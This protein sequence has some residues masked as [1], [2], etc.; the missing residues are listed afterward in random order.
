M[1]LSIFR[2]ILWLTLIG[3][4]L[5]A[6]G[7]HQVGGQLEMQ[8]IGDIPGH[9]RIVLTNYFEAGP[10]ADAQ[11]GGG[12]G[13]F[14]KRDNV[15]LFAFYAK[16]TGPGE[17]IVFSNEFCAKLRN[18]NFIT[19]NF[20]AEIQLDPSEY[21][22]SQGYYISYQ[23]RNR[24]VS[25]NNIKKSYDTGF[26][27]YLEF[28]PLQQSG[29][30]IKY[31]SPHFPPMTGEYICIG[32][33][34]RFPF[35]AT[36]PDGDQLTY[37]LVTPLDQ[38]IYT[39]AISPGPYP[40]VAWVPGYGPANA[41]H[42]SPP[43]AINAKTGELSVTA[44]QAGLFVFG[45][46]VEKYRNGRKLG[47]VRRDFQFL[48]IDCASETIP[49]PVV[50]AENQSSTAPEAT[51]CQGGSIVLQTTVDSNWNYQWYRNGSSIS[52]ANKPSLTIYEP[53]SYNVIVYS[54]NE[55]LKPGTSKNIIVKTA[56]LTS[57]IKASGS[58]CAVD[59]SVRLQASANLAVRYE[60]YHN[61]QPLTHQTADTV[62][63]SQEGTYWAVLTDTAF[64]CVF[65]TDTLS[66][67]RLPALPASI[68]SVRGSP[69]LC[70]EDSLLL[71]SSRGK[72]Y[73]WQRDGQPIQGA[74]GAQYQAKTSGSY[75]VRITDDSGCSHVSE[76]FLVEAI[77]PLTV[78]FDSIP[79]ICEANA[80]I[81]TLNASPPG[82]TFSGN[83][84]GGNEFDP[85]LAGIGNHRL[86]YAIKPSPEC[87]DVVVTRTVVVGK[88]PSI[89]LPDSIVTNK[90]NTIQL[91]PSISTNAVFFQWTPS[92]Y[93]DNPTIATPLAVSVLNTITYTVKASDSLGCASEDS[94]RIKIIDQ[95]WVP[96]AFTPNGDGMNDVLALPGIEAFPDAVIT[97]Y[98]RWG[99]VIY[100]SA[101]G[102]PTPFD[103][104]LNGHELPI[105]VYSY[106][107]QTGSGKPQ[108]EGSIL[109]LRD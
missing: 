84:V 44:T 99:E 37:S 66:I 45:V 49:S 1:C 11:A 92:T 15:M 88:S 94:V 80:T 103:G 46:K 20:E 77:P 4:S 3:T 109:L 90:G 41:I 65:R 33:P 5:Q 55:C 17:P 39:Q 31:S 57:S 68:R 76:P 81:I 79:A 2:V 36:D 75:V 34:F 12:L 101:K 73:T 42:G 21:S 32:E 78:L 13:V 93:L 27:Y 52:A 60:W 64:G 30:P 38:K 67:S 63:V 24:N 85:R 7:A 87:A 14:R 40:G 108:K 74:T 86:S 54:K 91:T 8:A 62:R 102:Y 96:D 107:L 59:G 6:L 9:Y 58:L 47:E 104:T 95:I 106:R 18:L 56:T 105:G 22:D 100:Q 97:I 19:V 69:R 23:G 43:L 61:G 98:N 83:G 89:E 70:P 25:I 53:G 28:P 48:V 26:T 71:E 29:K 51:I 50:H 10:R 82:G 35:G 72:S 16:R